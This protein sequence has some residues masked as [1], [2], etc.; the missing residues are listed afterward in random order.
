M[1]STIPE[2]MDRIT[3]FTKKWNQE[4][5]KL[6]LGESKRDYIWPYSFHLCLCFIVSPLVCYLV[7]SF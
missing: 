2:N 1:I 5:L 4:S 6:N 7:L 3:E